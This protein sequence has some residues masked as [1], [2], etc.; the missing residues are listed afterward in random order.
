MPSKFSDRIATDGEGIVDALQ[1]EY[2]VSTGNVVTTENVVTTGNVVS[3]LV[4]VSGD[5]AD[6]L[7]AL[8][9][10]GREE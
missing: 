10:R 7:L 1:V 6:T 2:R 5:V 8:Y 3:P 9:R 4:G